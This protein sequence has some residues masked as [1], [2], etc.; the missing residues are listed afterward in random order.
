M[1]G[2]LDLV[3]HLFSES[4]MG[5]GEGLFRIDNQLKSV[6]AR[7][8]GQGRLDMIP[9]EGG[10]EVQGILEILKKKKLNERIQEL[11]EIQNAKHGERTSQGADDVKWDAWATN[12]FSSIHQPTYSEMTPDMFGDAQAAYSDYKQSPANILQLLKSYVSGKP[13]PA[14]HQRG[15]LNDYQGDTPGGVE[16]VWPQRPTGSR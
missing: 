4:R 16:R 3:K 5:G 8:E 2:P 13:G 15:W 11:V 6:R 12:N 1:A 9:Q 14:Y 7:D 10:L